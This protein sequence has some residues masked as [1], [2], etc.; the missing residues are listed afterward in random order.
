MRQPNL[1]IP[2]DNGKRLAVSWD[3]QRS[4]LHVSLWSYGDTNTG[5]LFLEAS[6]IVDVGP[7]MAEEILNP[8]L[9]LTAEA[10]RKLHPG[11]QCPL[12]GEQKG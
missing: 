7:R 10:W 4:L 11:R 5:V 3:A 6:G 12:C 2:L 1:Q 8:L 9:R